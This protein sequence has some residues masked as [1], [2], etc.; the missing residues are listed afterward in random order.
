VDPDTH[1]I[2]S[3]P[4]ADVTPLVTATYA[5]PASATQYAI[6]DIIANNA[7]AASVTPV[8]FTLPRT[9]G[10]IT[11]CRAV[12]TA[13]SG[14]VVLPAFDLLLFR[15]ATDIP[16]AAAGYPADNAALTVSSAAMLELVG[17]ISFSAT[18]WRNSAGGSTAAGA[19]VYQ[20]QGFVTRPYAPF[21]VNGLAASTVLGL[22]QAQSTWNPGNVAQSFA[23]ALDVA[24]D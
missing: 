1:A 4:G 17:V 23:F 11:G 8:T 20:A 21:N 14:T 15:P 6:G 10:I 12:L 24:L 3:S 13:A 5:K 18:G 9:S 7:T 22:L 2:R 16:F 19:Q